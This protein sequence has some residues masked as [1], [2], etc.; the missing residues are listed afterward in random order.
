MKQILGRRP[1][2]AMAVALAALVVALGG[3]AFAA[4]PD[5][6]GEIH[7]CFKKANGDLRLVDSAVSCRSSEKAIAWN[8]QRPPGSGGGAVV[9]RP[10]SE[11]PQTATNSLADYPLADNTW[12]QQAGE[13]DLV[14]AEIEAT[15]PA[16]CG[17]ISAVR[18]EISINGQVVGF[19]AQVGPSAFKDIGSGVLFEPGSA[20]GRTA[21]VRI[22]DDCTTGQHFTVNSVK[23]VVLGFD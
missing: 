22:Q 11:T 16:D 15:P 6:S 4:I 3:A 9:A 20:T 18:A 14:F 21:T 7:G 1:S 23:V 2:P 10:R 19:A 12:T 5:S 17:G 13:T 8:Q